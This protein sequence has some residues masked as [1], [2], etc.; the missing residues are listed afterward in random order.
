MSSYESRV[1]TAVRK[2]VKSGLRV[3][4]QTGAA[5]AEWF[6]EFY[7]AAMAEIGAESFYFFPLSYFRRLL[8]WEHTRLGVCMNHDEPVAA[9]LFLLGPNV[10]EYHLSASNQIGKRLGG[11]TLLIHEAAQ[12]AKSAGCGV[13]YLG[14][15]TDNKPDNPLLFFK[16]GFS[17]EREPFKIGGHVHSSEGYCLLKKQFSQAF[18]AHP[19]RVLF[20][21]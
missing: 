17:S 5:N 10:M 15:G 8:D 4:W 9:A 7:S 14:G 21:R 13:M 6:A 11:T 1:R 12:L 16:A 3:E 18:D 19:G 20:Y 2:A